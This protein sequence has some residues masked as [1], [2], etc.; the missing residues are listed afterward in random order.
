MLNTEDQRFNVAT[1]ILFQVSTVDPDSGNL[2][3]MGNCLLRVFSNDG[4]LNVGGFQLKLR[5]GMPVKKRDL[6]VPPDFHQYP[7]LPCCSLLIR[8]LPHTENPVPMPRYSV[9]FYFTHEA[10][11]T[12]SELQ[13]MSTFQKDV[14]FPILV[15][16]MAECLREKGESQAP[17]ENELKGWCVEKIDGTRSS[18]VQPSSVYINIHH[19]TKY[20]QEIGVHLKIMQ[21]F[22]LEVEGLYIN[23]FARILK[24]SQSKHL[25]ELPQHWG[26][27]EKFLTRQ[28]DF[29][30]L[31]KSPRWTDPSVVLHPYL[32]NHSVLLVQIF[33]MTAVYKPHPSNDQ[34]GRVISQNGQ[35]LTL[36]S[37]LGWTVFPLFDRHYVYSG[38][39]SAPL[40]QGAPNAEFLQTISAKS[41]K[42]A[43]EEGLKKKSLTLLKTY[44]S[45]TIKVWDGHYF[46]DEHYAL[47]VINDLL[48]V[49]KIKKFLSTQ[50]SK[51]GKEMSM[52]VLQ[53]LDK[54]KQKLQRN[55]PEYQQHQHFY[56]EAMADAFYNLIETALLNAGYG[57]L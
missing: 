40:F 49:D 18:L 38:I 6:L 56:E 42:T 24:G 13:I 26:G 53:S 25:P 11:P 45:V 31:Q 16:D 20:R 8:I 51:K 23:A 33:G 32:D 54:K 7:V 36:H 43:I 9:G 21:A 15:K 19:V 10:K 3:I 46:D 44:G 17:Q 14:N 39:H 28:H 55:N 41:L 47:P 1:S 22:G 52:L 50:T 5:A 57:P 2:V 35:D 12:R 37:L 34:R 27:E 4:K 48:T 30:S 29:S